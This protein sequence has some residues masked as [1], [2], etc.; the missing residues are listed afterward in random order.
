MFKRFN[1]F[2]ILLGL[3]LN[4]VFLC[5]CEKDINTNPPLTTEE[6]F[7]L[8]IY[9]SGP[10]I[11][12][13]SAPAYD[14][15]DMNIYPSLEEKAPEIY[16]TNEKITYFGDEHTLK[17]NKMY[18]QM[19][20]DLEFKNQIVEIC[21]DLANELIYDKI[22]NEP[23]LIE[24]RYRKQYESYEKSLSEGQ[25]LTE[26]KLD[27]IAKAF[28]EDILNEKYKKGIDLDNYGEPVITPR[29]RGNG[30]RIDYQ[31]VVNNV[32]VHKI[33]IEVDN[34]GE[35]IYWASFP[36]PPEDVIKR[37]PNVSEEQYME[38]A[39]HYIKTGYE[40]CGEKVTI[41]NVKKYYYA[42]DAEYG[43][44]IYNVSRDDY[45]VHYGASY[46]VENENG[47]AAPEFFKYAIPL[48]DESN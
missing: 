39:T 18:S 40:K 12:R 17:F 34:G 7:A 5:A 3:I 4:S 45:A 48:Y 15:S 29:F 31:Y 25:E 2:V 28:I 46:Y 16:E 44:L 20:L 30:H 14:Y 22:T 36:I 8:P 9:F 23:Y 1:S 10:A 13:K 21:T 11:K 41:Y 38:L 33:R 6:V 19:Y 42:S 32:I 24:Y 47:D 37:I 26:E 43:N 35:V 27:D